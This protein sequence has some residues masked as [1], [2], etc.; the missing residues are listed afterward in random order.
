MKGV[1]TDLQPLRCAEQLLDPIKHLLCGFVRE[2]NGKNL[3]RC[4]LMVSDKMCNSVGNNIRLAGA[5]SR[6][7]QH[8]AVGV[9]CGLL[10]L[11]IE[12]L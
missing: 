8:R 2:G 7:N 5:W 11:L 12:F 4:Y 1:D 3:L 9:R 6:Y 10:L